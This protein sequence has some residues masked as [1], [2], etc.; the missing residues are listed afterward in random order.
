MK[1]VLIFSDLHLT[2]SSA[3]E[4]VLILEEI[5]MLVNKHN[6][7]T[8]IS[9]GDTFDSVKP[10]SLE[11]DLLATFIRRINKNIIILAADSHESETKEQSILNHYGILSNNVKVV[12]EFKDGNHLYCGHFS[13]KE[14]LSNYDAKL[15]KLDFKNYLYVFLG[16]IHSHQLIKPNILHLGSCR[17]VNFDEAKDKAKIVAL[18][19]NYNAEGEKVH[20]LKL[21]TPI[22]M[23]EIIL[24]SNNNNKLDKKPE[25]KGVAEP[26]LSSNRG[27]TEP[28]SGKNPLNLRDCQAFL[29]N[30]PPK[31]KIKVKIT[32]FEAFRE[33]LPLC[34]KYYTKFETFKYTTDFEVISANNQKCI[35]TEMTSFKESLSNYL[36]NNKIDESIR[37]ILEEEIK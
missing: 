6:V 5:G 35:S 19:T 28:G 36:K 27:T 3:K 30:L 16:H 8:L 1:N 12:K 21:Q 17:Y 23:V 33:F 2:Q 20:F 22:P 4:C 14:S 29:D 34:H 9:L 32:D 37:K 31:Y 24:N 11:L 7:D 18:I 26:S 25:N 13:I 10:S 15:S